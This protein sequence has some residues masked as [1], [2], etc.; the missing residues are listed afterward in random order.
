MSSSSRAG[1]CV[2]KASA[3]LD[4]SADRYGLKY[5]NTNKLL[6]LISKVME[7]ARKRNLRNWNEIFLIVSCAYLTKCSVPN[8]GIQ[9]IYMGS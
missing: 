1:T 6:S 9:D 7:L 3:I 8:L 4:M 5:C 2:L